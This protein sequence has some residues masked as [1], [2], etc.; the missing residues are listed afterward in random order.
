MIITVG[1][2]CLG[3]SAIIALL[4]GLLPGITR[5]RQFSRALAVEETLAVSQ[6]FLMLT[7][8]ASLTYAYVVSDFSVLNVAL[9]SHSYASLLYKISGVWG[10]HEGSMLLLVL[11]LTFFGAAFALSSQLLE[12]SF[13]LI[14]L[15]VQGFICL[16]FHLFLILT[17]NPF[18]RFDSTPLQ[19]R[20]LNPILEDPSLS[21]H[22][23]FLFMGYFGFSLAFSFAVAGLLQGKIDQIWARA[24][25]F[26]SLVSWSF[27]TLGLAM[28][29]WWAYYELGWGGW[30]FWDPVENAALMPWLAG[31]ALIH[32]LVVV[33]KRDALKNWAVLLAILTFGL[34]LIG[35]FLVRSGILTSVHSFALDP[36]RGLFILILLATILGTGLF[37]FALRAPRIQAS[38]LKY[39]LSRE[40]ALVFNNV[41]LCSF[42]GIV[43]IGTLYPLFLEMA[44]G[45]QISVWAPY[46]NQ[47]LAPLFMPFV[48]MMAIAPFLGWNNFKLSFVFERLLVAFIIAAIVMLA[49]WYWQHGGPVLAIL[50]L[51]CSAWLF[52]GTLV[53]WW[54][55]VCVNVF[56][57]QFRSLPLSGHGMALAHLGVAVTLAG[58][59]L[60]VVGREEKIENMTIG[61]SVTI[62]GSELTL[63]KVGYVRAPHYQQEQAVIEVRHGNKVTYLKP[64]KRL[65]PLHQT[66][67]TETALLS[68][69]FSNIYVALG[70][71]QGNNTWTI[72]IYWHP[73]V[74]WIWLG[75][76]L[77]AI[78]GL[79]SA[80]GLIKR[81]RK[82]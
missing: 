82:Q 24:L 26:W 58:M 64:E 1:Y 43:F 19:G 68:R 40:G 51:G 56:K 13:R 32:T 45:E 18:V 61:E 44:T 66:L 62:A 9:N 60:D 21:W 46:F 7:A 36:G 33:E 28:G 2:F 54:D 53:H 27:L 71:F 72:R 73:M 31:T 79:L 42:V 30:W 74:T 77:M 35:T 75:A 39:P 70:D 49:T 15:S 22:P 52:T 34:S 41:M 16:G 47:T 17:S 4:Q 38:K 67:T 23:P 69:G 50:A 12:R 63:L 5:F 14:V 76:V 59:T 29:S 78:G 8:F 6:A 65:Y 3:L 57:M 80:L 81:R 10:N 20:G 48:G 25:R 11:I 37:L 55:R